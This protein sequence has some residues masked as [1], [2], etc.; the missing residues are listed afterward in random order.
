MEKDYA[1]E[2]GYGLQ[3]FAEFVE[4]AD[5]GELEEWVEKNGNDYSLQKMILVFNAFAG[6]EQVSELIQLPPK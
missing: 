5:K 3:L 1:F 4:L 6:L 2:L